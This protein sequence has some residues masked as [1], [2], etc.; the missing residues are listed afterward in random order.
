M[1]RDTL[2]GA[3]VKKRR[4]YFTMV[5]HPLGAKRV[6][7]AYATKQDARDAVPLVRGAWRGLRVKISQCTIVWRD[8]VLCPKSLQTLDH[9]YNMD[10]PKEPPCS[11]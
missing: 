5:C 8:G 2:P 1:T 11:T 7:N 3:V 6:G 9:K 10:P 4:L